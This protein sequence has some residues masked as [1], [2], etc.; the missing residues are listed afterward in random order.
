M[1]GGIMDI[2][3]LNKFMYDHGFYNTNNEDDLPKK[4]VCDLVESALS[5][6][7]N[8]AIIEFTKKIDEKLTVFV[9]EHQ[10]QLDF[11]SGVGVA[12]KII[13]DIAE[14]MGCPRW[15]R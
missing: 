3:E 9:L 8:K 6:G 13:D 12:W 1:K 14:Q 10:K 15:E 5:E 4:Y 2:K 7:R 11:V